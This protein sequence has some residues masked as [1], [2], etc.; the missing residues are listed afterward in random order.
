MKPME[1]HE[2]V[3]GLDFELSRN[4]KVETRYSRK[5]LDRTIEDVGF[6]GA[7]GETY[8][9]G[10]P[11]ESILVNPV[12]DVC[13]T[14]PNQPKATRN[15]D[16]VEFKVRKTWSQN[17]FL[18]GSYTYSRL[19]GNYSGLSSTD[20]EGRHSP[21]VNR[22]FDLPHMTWDSHGQ[23]VFG[24]LNTDRPN[25]FKMYGAYRLKWFGME[26]TLGAI[27]LAYSGTPFGTEVGV[28]GSGTSTSFVEGRGN[29]VEITRN[30]AVANCGQ[31]DGI[32][33]PGCWVAGAIR[34]NQRIE[35]FSQTQF[36]VVHDFRLS[37][38]N[39]ALKAT[40]E[41]NVSN[42]FNQNHAL[43]VIRTPA[44]T[45]VLTFPISGSTT[46]D[47][48]DVLNGYDYIAKANF[49]KLILDPRYGQ[50]NRFQDPRSVRLKLKVSF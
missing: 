23:Q 10:N 16:G 30:P 34:S 32:A 49:S 3:T 27:Q 39:E 11:G 46:P 18:E 12:A 2:F 35:A 28:I 26:T 20:E 36:L 31:S 29:F 44:R 17:W 19:F 45:G 8:Y 43:N 5:R 21:N 33:A 38:T 9:I 37:K 48:A 7:Q 22:F 4:W 13:P 24:L 6:F 25:T 41:L 42:L 15:Y 14:C 40:V 47:W 50:T 1:Q